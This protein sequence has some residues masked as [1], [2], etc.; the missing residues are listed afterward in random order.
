MRLTCVAALTAI[1]VAASAAPETL[2][3]VGKS[4]RSGKE[5]AIFGHYTGFTT[6]SLAKPF[7]VGTHEALA[8]PFVHPGPDDKWAGSK[9]HR[10]PIQFELKSRPTGECAL[11]VDLVDVQGGGCDLQASLN[12]EP[13]TVPL[14]GGKGDPS[15]T[16]ET[17][18]NPRAVR[19]P[20]HPELLNRGANR[21]VIAITRGSWLLYDA[22]RLETDPAVS[23]KRFVVSAPEQSPFFRRSKSGPLPTVMVPVKNFSRSVEVTAV[24]T[25]GGRR[26]TDRVG[27]PFGESILPVSFA[28]IGETASVNIELRMAGEKVT[29]VTTAIPQRKW[30]IF[31]APSSHTDIGYTDQQP[32]IFKRHNDNLDVA[33]EMCRDN[34]LFSWNLEVSWQWQNYLAN[35]GKDK[36]SQALRLMRSGRVGAHGAYLNMLPSLMSDEA[37]NRYGYLG[38]K[39][40][41][42]LGVDTSVAILTDVPSATWAVASA[43]AASGVPYYAEGCN[44]DRGPTLKISGIRDPF[45]WEGPDGARVLAFLT[46]SYAQSL[47]MANSTKLEQ[48]QDHV[49]RLVRDHDRVD[50]P[51]DAIYLFGA[52]FDNQPLDRRY[53]NL[54]GEWK[55]KWA[56]PELIVSRSAGFFR[57]IEN[58]FADKI[59]VRRCDFGAYWEDGAGS[60]AFETSLLMESYRRIAAAETLAAMAAR[61]GAKAPAPEAFDDAWEKILFY[62]EHTWG[63]HDS[64]HNP[65]SESVARQW[66]FKAR[67]AHDADRQTSELL[68][69]AVAAV[70]GRP[71]G[72]EGSVQAV[73]PLSWRRSGL[74]ELPDGLDSNR[75]GRLQVQ[76]SDG[77]KYAFVEEVPAWGAGPL[78]AA[79]SVKADSSA[80]GA[81]E[82]SESSASVTLSNRYYEISATRDGGITG[83]VDKETGRQ[84][85]DASSPYR[86]AGIVYASGGADTKMVH[87]TATSSP[88]I[89]HNDAKWTIDP[90]KP[91]KGTVVFT[92]GRV[93]AVRVAQQGPLWS[94]LV[95]TEEAPSM[96]DVSTRVRLHH[97]EKRIG[98][99]VRITSKTE[100][101]TKEAVYVA[102][103]MAIEKPEWRLG[104][105]NSIA[106]PD[107]DFSRGACNEWYCVQDFVSCRGRDSGAETIVAPLDAPLVCLSLPN[108][109]RWPA[110][111]ELTTATLFSYAMNNYW[112]TNYKAG[113]GGDFRFRYELTSVSGDVRNID[114][115][116]FARGAAIPLLVASTLHG[117][118]RGQASKGTVVV[119]SEDVVGHLKIAQD[120]QG[121]IARLRNVEETTGTATVRTASSWVREADLVEQTLPLKTARGD[122][123]VTLRPQQITTFRIE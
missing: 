53:G 88:V 102:F 99:D 109:G 100:I 78:T 98:I 56:Y 13:L 27:L 103:P 4:D 118:G 61:A 17:K 14:G 19:I 115:I 29:T 48:M 31:I 112:H 20:F 22:I 15:L 76:E 46:N 38:A 28:D 67:Y 54:L 92:G 93:K 35:R 85:V 101:R 91:E 107:R 5:F 84:L 105:T 108:T 9:V 73:N 50:Y 106:R 94:D 121:V 63:A 86:F 33:L 58:K 81:D 44:S 30:K 37:M 51:Y 10:L 2:W 26:R 3:R 95:V 36:I 66:A 1:A 34:P 68:A 69:S 45:Y 79:K 111:P 25:V 74:A 123:T 113:Q 52:F 72:A 70:A 32:E 49:R 21:L 62:A 117:G 41:R 114:R 16:D 82:G 80:G 77:R 43:F 65:D 104:L 55:A 23:P 42:E 75:V 11:V 110:E 47:W 6:A 57:H 7:I 89:V 96:P 8:W 122:R 90:L 39:M 12:G 18:G 83:I 87:E 24:S 116:R 64:I 71:H 119:D 60:T 40:R 120:G 97:Y 59:P